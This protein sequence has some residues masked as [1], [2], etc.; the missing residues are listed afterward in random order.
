M[1]CTTIIDALL[2]RDYL[3]RQAKADPAANSWFRGKI[4]FESVE[5]LQ[6]MSRSQV[7]AAT[8]SAAAVSRGLMQIAT[9]VSDLSK[10]SFEEGSAVFSKLIGA[11]SIDG[12]MQV[13]SDFA[14]SSYESM[15]TGASRVGELMASLA[16]DAYR[17]FEQVQGAR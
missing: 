13:Q 1:R 14:K 4:M 3:N 9:E 7:E 5:N 8:R 2:R 17:P 16:K 12:A 15:M 11:K 10:K 6:Q